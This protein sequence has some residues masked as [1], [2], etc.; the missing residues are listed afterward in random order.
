MAALGTGT[1]RALVTLPAAWL[2]QAD[3]GLA[4]RAARNAARAVAEEQARRRR[5]E[6]EAESS[7]RLLPEQR[8]P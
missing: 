3:A 1:G 2:Q 7:L 8:R 6:R 4:R 5:W